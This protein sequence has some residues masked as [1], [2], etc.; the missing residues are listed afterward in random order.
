[1][2]RQPGFRSETAIHAAVDTTRTNHSLLRKLRV[3]THGQHLPFSGGPNSREA[4]VTQGSH[5]SE[6]R[7]HETPDT[8]SIRPSG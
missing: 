7:R 5:S 2:T 6:I 3:S 4:T 1:M 8:S